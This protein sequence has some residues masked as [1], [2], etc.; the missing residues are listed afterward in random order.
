MTGR[1][2]L[3]GFVWGMTEALIKVGAVSVRSRRRRRP[4]MQGISCRTIGRSE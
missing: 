2:T 1:G 4:A 3:K